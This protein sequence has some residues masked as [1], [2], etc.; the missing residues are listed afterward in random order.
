MDGLKA[1]VWVSFSSEIL[2]FYD[3]LGSRGLNEP[4]VGF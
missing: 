4:G 3:D 1:K 2:L